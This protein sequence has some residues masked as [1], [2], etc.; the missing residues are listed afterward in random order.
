MFVRMAVI[1]IVRG[2][3]CTAAHM[4]VGVFIRV[5]FGEVGIKVSL[6]TA[7]HIRVMFL[8]VGIIFIV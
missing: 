8:V 3:W 6:R 1:V 7:L 4:A 2:C 5:V